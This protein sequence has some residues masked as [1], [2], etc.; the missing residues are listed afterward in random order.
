M[1]DTLFQNKRELLS[2]SIIL[3]FLLNI[4]YVNEDIRTISPRLLGHFSNLNNIITAEAE[5]LCNILDFNEFLIFTFKLAKETSYRLSK[6]LI[7]ESSIIKKW[8][9]FED[10]LHITM[11]YLKTEKFRILFLS[12]ELKI[13]ADDLQDV[14]TINHTPIYIREIF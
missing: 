5:E 7:S 6:N 4:C 10:Y 1:Q 13:I 9:I 14:G 8:S 3:E 11:G 12:N 2:E